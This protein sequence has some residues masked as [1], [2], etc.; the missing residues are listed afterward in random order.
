M[1]NLKMSASLV[2]IMLNVSSCQSTGQLTRIDKDKKRFELQSQDDIRSAMHPDKDSSTLGLMEKLL[3]QA[4]SDPRDLTSRINLAQ[5]YLATQQ[6][7]K[8]EQRCREALRIDLKNELAKKVLAQIYYRRNNLE[9]AKIILNSLESSQQKDSQTLNL[10]GM[11]ALRENQPEY[12]LFNFQ[13]ALKINPSDVSVRMNLGVLY[14][15]FRQ[16]GLAAVEFERV[17]KVMPEHPDANLHLAIIEAN[18]GKLDR[19]EELNKNVL[20]KS[21]NNAIATFNLAVIEHRRKDFE[22][23][24]GY[25]KAY[26]DTEYAKKKNNQE[27]FAL[28]DKIRN[29]QEATTGKRVSDDEILKLAAKKPLPQPKDKAQEFYEPAQTVEKNPSVQATD[30]SR[31]K[32]DLPA[33]E[34]DEITANANPPTV[35]PQKPTKKTYRSDEEEIQDLEKQLK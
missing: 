34:D 18:R 33:K 3:Q 30:N 31:Q 12:A 16:L 24:L 17:L 27:V 25:L 2:F 22:K 26:L 9:M 5:A 6:L 11:I 28:I 14:V 32:A 15:Q 13:E 21:K 7:E 29:E 20:K 4:E 1:L 10:Q 23:S 19:A 35:A 8:S